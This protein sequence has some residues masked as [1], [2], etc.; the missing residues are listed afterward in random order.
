[1]KLGRINVHSSSNPE[2]Y[3][4]YT[5]E[6]LFWYPLGLTPYKRLWLIAKREKKI[7]IKGV[8]LCQ[9]TKWQ[10]SFFNLK[11]E[12]KEFL[13]TLPFELATQL[14][15]PK[16]KESSPWAPGHKLLEL[17]SLCEW[18]SLVNQLLSVISNN[19]NKHWEKGS[20][21]VQSNQS[22][23]WVLNCLRRKHM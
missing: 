14:S 23:I 2:G 5:W 9:R 13:Q 4:L 18:F 16:Q 7:F 3:H 10:S 21:I 20:S 11:E 8:V 12:T 6:G 15:H 17:W 22:L 19:D 1:M